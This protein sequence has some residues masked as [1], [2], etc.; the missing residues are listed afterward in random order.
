MLHPS[1]FVPDVMEEYF[2]ENESVVA[3]VVETYP[4]RYMKLIPK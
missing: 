2:V 4:Q 3:I 1:L